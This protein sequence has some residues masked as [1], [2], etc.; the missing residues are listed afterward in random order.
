[1][2]ARMKKEQK[3]KKPQPPVSATSQSKKKA[4]TPSVLSAF[5]GSN[6]FY[7]IA[8]AILVASVSIIRWRLVGMPLERDEGEYAYFSHL[9]R[10]GITPYKEAYKMKLPG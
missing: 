7:L 10:N 2:F 6:N 8:L 4:G 3:N 9:I 5:A 1:M